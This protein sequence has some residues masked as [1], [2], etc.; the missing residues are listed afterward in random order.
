MAQGE[1]RSMQLPHRLSLEERKKLT[2]AGV[3]EVVSFDE[4]AVVLKTGRGTLLVRGEG[5]HLKTLSLDGGQVA[6]DGTVTALIYE[7]PRREGGFFSRL[8][9]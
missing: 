1:E 9:G 2:V 7:E 5:L 3:T 6:V 4:T 8:F